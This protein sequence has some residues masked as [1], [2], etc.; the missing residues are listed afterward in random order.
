[1]NP[2][3]V[4]NAFNN[5]FLT[6]GELGASVAVWSPH[7]PPLHL[8][9]GFQ[10]TARTRAWLDETPVL[11][12]SATKGPASACVLHCMQEA[13]LPLQTRVA[14]IWPEFGAAGKAAVTVRMLLEHRAG[15]CALD[16]PPPVENRREVAT[17]LAAQTPAWEPGTA[18]GY[19]P[20]TFGFLLDELVRRL[21]GGESLGQYWRR[22]FAEPLGLD[23]WIGVPGDL[24]AR[25]APVFSPRSLLP[26]GDPFLSAFLTAGS[27]TS[28]SFASPKGLHSA[29]SMN[30][31]EART[32]CYPG[33]GGI[34]TASALA[35]FYAMLA[36]GGVWEGRRFLASSTMDAIQTGGVQ[37]ADRVLLMETAF[38]CGFMRDPV[39]PDATKTRRTFGPARSAFGHPGAGGS[40]A[41][42]DPEC[43]LGFAYVMNQMEPGVLPNARAMALIEALYEG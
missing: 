30:T 24:A 10:D 22:I 36:C 11:V 4:A 2:T 17:A 8:A 15:L 13:R 16:S 25:V 40:V 18:H 34:G 38:S 28:R 39:S 27:L 20:R 5:N 33:F 29:S 3:A 9:G 43:G 32:A 23:F 26:K 37:G 41:F 35:K 19:H 6:R 7:H 12:W 1:M 42:A 21:S 14:D 31:T